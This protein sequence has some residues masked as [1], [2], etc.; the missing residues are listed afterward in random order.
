MV[1]IILVYDVEVKRVAKVLKV[2]RK[3]L[4]WLQ[5]SVLEG[6]LS[7]SQFIKLKYELKGV[8]D[9]N[10]DSIIF[11]IFDR[12]QLYKEFIG[13]VKAYPSRYL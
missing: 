6:H 11:Y 5:N 3:Y 9:E 12:R 8:I 1:F 10:K 13:V 2:A 7:G 4:F